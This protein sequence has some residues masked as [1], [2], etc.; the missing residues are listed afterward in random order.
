M[1]ESSDFGE[2]APGVRQGAPLADSILG[3]TDEALDAAYEI[4]ER[5]QEENAGAPVARSGALS[6]AVAEA[7]DAGIF[8]TLFDGLAALPAVPDP[9]VTAEFV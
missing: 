3:I 6:G 9:S 8:S 5:A 7:L 2:A 4:L 1:E